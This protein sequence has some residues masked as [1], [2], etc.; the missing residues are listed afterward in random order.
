MTRQRAPIWTAASIY[1]MHDV[2]IPY[3]TYQYHTQ[4]WYLLSEMTGQIDNFIIRATPPWS[5]LTPWELL[6]FPYL[7]R[8][9][10]MELNAS[11][12]TDNELKNTY[13]FLNLDS[14]LL[15]LD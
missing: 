7:H 15:E 5:E 10:A 12:I 1:H 11:S 13:N 14:Q 4:Y 3:G 6:A 2:S 8:K 9:F